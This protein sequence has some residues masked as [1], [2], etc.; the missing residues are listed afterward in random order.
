MEMFLGGERYEVVSDLH[1]HTRY[2][3]GRGSIEDVVK[4]A[5][6]KGLKTIGISEHGPG[7]FGFGVPRKRL[8]EMK[9]E[10]IRLR[11][12][13]SDIEI[14]FG[15]EA[16]ILI[17]RK[18]LDVK[19]EEFEYFDYICAGWH[20]GAVDGITSASFRNTVQN[21]TRGTYEK[22]TRDQIRRNTDAVVRVVEAGGVKFVTHPGARAPF[23]LFEIVTACA[24]TGTLVELNAN[25]MVFTPEML[26]DIANMIGE[27]RFIISSD[28][29]RPERVGNFGRIEKL[30]NESELDPARVENLRKV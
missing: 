26:K 12:V 8:A 4:A 19:P 7:H 3:H 11:R 16:N 25:S 10:I 15:I 17:E 9:A 13:Y 29:H 24:N 1:T 22:G 14:L 20:F 18:C 21:F 2:S 23:D 5:V 6:A 28:A 27:A 30:L